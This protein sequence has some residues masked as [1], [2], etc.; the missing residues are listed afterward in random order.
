M[1]QKISKEKSNK[2]KTVCPECLKVINL[3]IIP[4]DGKI[5][6]KKHCDI[7]GDFKDIYWSDAALYG[8]YEKFAYEGKKISNP[9]SVKKNGC[10]LDC[11]L[12]PRHKTGTL[13]ANIDLTNRCNQKCPICFANS[14]V[15]GYLYEPSL[16][17]IEKMMKM[18]KNEKPVPCAAIQFSG[19]EPTIYP[20][21]IKVIKMARK[22]GFIQIQVATNGVRSAQDLNF[23]KEMA[24]A[25]LNT[26]YL[27][28]DGVKKETYQKIRGYN[29]FP[30]KLKALKN[31]REAGLSSVVLVPTIVKG[32]NDGQIGDIINFAKENS[33]IIKGINFQPISFS[34][35][36]DKEELKNKRN[37]IPD[38]LG[39]IEEQTGGQ[40][41]KKDFYPI[42]SIVPVSYFV[43]AWKK[44]AKT[45]FTVHPHCGAATYV[46]IRNNKLYPLAHFINIEKLLELIKE[47][48]SGLKEQGIINKIAHIDKIDKAKVIANLVNHLPDF[49]RTDM[50]SEAIKIIVEIIDIIRTGSPESL[51]KFHSHTLFI[52]TMH[53]M[54]PYNFDTERVSRCGIHYATPSMEIIPFCSYN[55]FYREKIEKKF[56]RSLNEKP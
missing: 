33:D 30:V 4:R 27:Q 44:S 5:L 39:L 17:Q 8:K 54:D 55:I 46:F 52:G 3:E 31:F 25:G 51:I 16:A 35:R 20:D 9:G 34:G 37:T 14:A 2:P 11:G 19:G 1:T 41:K 22:M 13:L 53:F 12:C 24:A 48:V 21:F 45:E 28:F 56:S 29:A 49:I 50:P 10:P 40:I 38:V 36:V 32:I 26:I 23:C 42:P 18:L 6:I 15:A 47:S 43:E 7:H